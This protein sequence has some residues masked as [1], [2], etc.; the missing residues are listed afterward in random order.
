[1]AHEKRGG[2]R[3]NHSQRMN[4]YF[5]LIKFFIFRSIDENSSRKQ[6]AV[7]FKS[8]NSGEVRQNGR[9]R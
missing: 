6:V 4:F 7:L 1:M 2:H 3:K 9:R 8:S 5:H